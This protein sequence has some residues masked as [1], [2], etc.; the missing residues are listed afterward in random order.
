MS[1][2]NSLREK[3][4]IEQKKKLNIQD[5]KNIDVLFNYINN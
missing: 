5:L 3:I 4:R 2:L 1:F